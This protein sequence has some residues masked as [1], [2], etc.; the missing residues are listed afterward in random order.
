MKNAKTALVEIGQ[1]EFFRNYSPNANF[2]KLVIQATNDDASLNA[3]QEKFLTDYMK[4][5]FD[6][7]DTKKPRTYV[8]QVANWINSC[9]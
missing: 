8:A 6:A 7:S 2:V 5:A 4:E 1:T 3:E 9:K